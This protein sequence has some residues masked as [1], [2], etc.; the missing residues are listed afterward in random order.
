MLPRRVRDLNPGCFAHCLHPLLLFL[1]AVGAEVVGARARVLHL[2]T[3]RNAALTVCPVLLRLFLIPHLQ[4]TQQ[5]STHT[6]I[7]T[8]RSA[9]TNRKSAEVNRHKQRSADVNKLH[10]APMVR[11]ASTQIM[12][13]SYH[14]TSPRAE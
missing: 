13:N 1:L 5:K 8:Q 11:A 4:D 9:D 3:E 6:S 10:W 14:I 7:H 12:Q 2:Q